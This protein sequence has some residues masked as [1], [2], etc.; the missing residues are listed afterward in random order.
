MFLNK[1]PIQITESDGVFEMCPPGSMLVDGVCVGVG[2][3]DA[4]KRLERDQKL[5]DYNVDFY[6]FFQSTEYDN[7]MESIKGQTLTMDMYD[8][9]YFG[10]QSSGAYRELDRIY[11]AYRARF[12][13]LDDIRQPVT[14][15]TELK[16]TDASPGI[17]PMLI[18]AAVAAYFIAG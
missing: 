17:S 3:P 14:V 2:N 16:R 18:L 8:S 11:E 4:L 12:V 9:P 6:G 15:I 1:T 13:D 5:L 10:M 7:W